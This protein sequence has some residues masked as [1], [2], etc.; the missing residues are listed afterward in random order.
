MEMSLILVKQVL[1]M[2]LM[3]VMGFVATKKKIVNG[4]E[5]RIISKVLVYVVTPCC[6]IDAF[7]GEFDVRKIEALGIALILS[8]VFYVLYL[9]A[10]WGMERG[11]PHLTPGEQCS[12]LYCNSGN[13]VIP[14][15]GGVVGG[16]FVIYTCAFMFAQSMFMWTHGQA[17]LGGDPDLSVKKILTNTCIAS[18]LVG[19]VLFLLNIQL[20]G[21]LGT[22]VSSMGSCIGPFSMLVTGV[23][24]AEADLKGAFTHMRTYLVM[25]MRLIIYPLGSMV[26]LLIVGRIWD[27]PQKLDVLTVLMLCA[28]APPASAV[29]Q[30]A[31]LYGSQE[32]R[33]ISSI[34]AV[35]TVLSAVTMPLLCLLF[36]FLMGA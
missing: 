17:K 19:L 8:F 28:S 1:A 6:L 2:A 31:Q 27:H 26:L 5:C 21:A 32:S 16:E 29:T 24:L 3:V 14:I 36:R 34:T 20:P 13:L 4:E 10:A 33:Y 12:V 7:Q 18:M 35:S 11:W 25:A 9:A 30:V 23:L 22:A 15:V